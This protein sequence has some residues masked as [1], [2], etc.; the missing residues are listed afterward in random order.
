MQN[1]QPSGAGSTNAL[2]TLPVLLFAGTAVAGAILAYPCRLVMHSKWGERALI[3][4]GV[5]TLLIYGFTL[6][7]LPGAMHVFGLV[8]PSLAA[9][10]L[11]KTLYLMMV[12]QTGPR[13]HTWSMGGLPKLADDMRT[14]GLSNLLV[15]GAVNK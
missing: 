4:G 5:A 14:K 15:L 3:L 1:T 7:F 6:S 8:F 12:E 9:I 11:A 2:T 10:W 13:P